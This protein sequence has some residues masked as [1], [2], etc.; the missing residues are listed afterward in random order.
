MGRE[1]TD[2]HKQCLAEWIRSDSVSSGPL[3]KQAD[4]K[5]V[6]AEEAETKCPANHENANKWRCH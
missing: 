5:R 2:L 1:G 6:G 4:A 3:I